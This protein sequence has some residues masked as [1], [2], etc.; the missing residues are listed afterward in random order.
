MTRTEAL[1]FVS[2]QTQEAQSRA[3]KFHFQAYRQSPEYAAEAALIGY[4]SAF[5]PGPDLPDGMRAAWIERQ[6]HDLAN[7]IMAPFLRDEFRRVPLGWIHDS[8]QSVGKVA[9]AAFREEAPPEQTEVQ[10]APQVGISEFAGDKFP[11]VSTPPDGAREEDLEEDCEEDLEEEWADASDPAEGI[12]ATQRAIDLAA[13]HRVDLSLVD[14]TGVRGRV[15]AADV[16]R[17]M[18]GT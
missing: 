1:A 10:K 2:R 4:L 7:L 6:A 5:S 11:L 9:M 8:I 13:E 14:G 16:E 12:D 18:D 15:T 3:E 17:F